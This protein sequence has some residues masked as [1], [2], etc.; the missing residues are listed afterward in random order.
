MD[1]KQR[2]LIVDDNRGNLVALR[3]VLRE[4]DAELVEA[5]SGNEALVATLHTDFAVAIL[6]IQMPDMNGYGLAE[7][8]RGHGKTRAIPLLFITASYMDEQS[9]FKGCAVGAVDY[10]VKPYAPDVLI[11]KIRVFLELDQHRRGVQ[12]RRDQLDAVVAERTAELRQ[13]NE[14]LGKE[15]AERERAQ[16]RLSRLNRVLRA[17][18]SVNQLIVREKRRD[19]LV[20]QACEILTR[21]HGF[22]GA[23]IVLTDKLPEISEAA[24][25]GFSETA[26][27]GLVALF[28]RGELPGCRCAQPEG[29]LVVIENAGDVCEA[30]PLKREYEDNPRLTIGLEHDGQPYGYL[31]VSVPL[32]F[33]TDPEE[34]SL[35]NEIVGDVSFGLHVTKNADARR[36]SER[37]LST[38]FDSVTDGIL[39]ADATTHRFVTANRALCRMLGYSL[40]ELK[41]LS[42]AD[43]HPPEDLPR[44][45]AEFEKQL[46]GEKT[47]ALDLPVRRKDGAVFFAD[48]NSSPIELAGCPCLLGVFRDTTERKQA[49]EELRKLSIAVTQSP[50]SVVITDLQ[51]NIE[52]VNPKFT[53]ITGYTLEEVRGQNPRLLKSGETSKE[54]Y[55]RLWETIVSGGEWRGQFHNKRK[56]GTLFWERAHI[57]PVRDT[58]G[59]ITHFL[60]IKED[61]T[62][63]KSLEDQYRQARKMEA[64]GQLAG[65][66][67]HDFNNI[68]Q[69]MV[70]YSDMLL[71]QLPEQ[72]KTHEFA[73]EIARGAERAAVLTRQLLAFSRRQVLEMEDLDLNEIV[74]GIMK[75]IKRVIG[76]NIE[77]NVLAGRRLGTV[78]ADRGQME[79]VL[80]NLS[81]NARDAMPE[82]G[83]LAIETEN[84]SFD[85]AYCATH[86]WA[87]P[88][89]YVLLSVTDTGCGMDPE[90]KEHLFEPFFTTKELGKGTGLGLATVYGIV[91][92][93]NGMIQVYSEVGSGTTF[94]IYLPIVERA[95]STVGAKVLRRPTGGTETILIAEDDPS[96]LKTAT[97]ILESAGYTVLTATNG[98]E[99]LRVFRECGQKIDLVL[100]DVVMPELGGRAL[101]DELHKRD[102]RLRF[103]FSS[104]YSANAVHTG[105]ILHKGIDFIQKPYARDT[106]LRKVQEVLDKK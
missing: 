96:V 69:A 28:Q 4:V 53:E 92:Q 56:D 81:V 74:Q 33:V 25:A 73:E 102:P 78:H 26:F 82:G 93:H 48:I 86:A 18:R 40:E 14:D 97:L 15:I 41:N 23:W 88:G 11:G 34:M 101:H 13:R 60:G 98:R 32:D 105:F 89:R 16:E 70:G 63:Q 7:L 90:A 35:L 103:L 80:M 85:D 22:N 36:E 50:A 21:T 54:E 64:I 20:R 106:L 37:T 62:E 30:C 51:G 44:I 45:A 17:V 68:L 31:G 71:D 2:I 46:Q 6:D 39:L 99:A 5:V 27:S 72:D 3:N 94:K 43:I 12:R 95:A 61:I 67:A 83:V 19:Q 76:E 58:T 9:I 87:A 42:V 91:R 75:M 77:V 55:L 57:S 47:L 29:S 49:E 65:G 79:Q 59:A 100:L 38:I 66:V 1:T 52:Y 84:V 10:I 8:L 24:Q 104:G